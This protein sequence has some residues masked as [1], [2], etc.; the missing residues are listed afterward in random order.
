MKIKTFA[1]TF[2]LFL[3]ILGFCSP[4][5]VAQPIKIDSSKEKAKAILAQAQNSIRKNKSING[6]NVIFDIT[7]QINS[8]DL[9]NGKAD[10]SSEVELSILFPNQIYQNAFSDYAT[11]Q[12]STTSILNN[13]NFSEQLNVFVD[14]KP[15]N[16]QINDGKSAEQKKNEQMLKLKSDAFWVTFPITLDFSWYQNLEFSFVGVA[17]T[18]TGKL[19]VI[20]SIMQNGSKVKLFFNNKTHLLQIITRTWASKATDKS[21]ERKYYFSDYQTKDG[22]LFAQSIVVEQ[23]GKTIEERKVK[24]LQINPKFKS[25]LFEV[26]EK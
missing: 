1:I 7:G 21:V 9:P 17:E 5:L 2:I 4:N 26:K 3:T 24:K 23:D 20:E 18:N 13:N 11:N 10:F 8:P 14:G 15:M 22:V 25:T 6:L 12:T 16:F 19:D